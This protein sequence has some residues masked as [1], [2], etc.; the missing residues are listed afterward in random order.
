[1]FVESPVA[2]SR[3]FSASRLVINIAIFPAA[4]AAPSLSSPY[5]NTDNILKVCSNTD[6]LKVCRQ[7]QTVYSDGAPLGGVRSRL[8]A[9]GIY[10]H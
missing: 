1:M 5:E 6:N 2:H 10:G 8:W 9:R 3:T 4:V 7:S